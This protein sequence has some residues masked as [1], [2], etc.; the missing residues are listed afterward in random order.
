[1][2]DSLRRISR[3]AGGRGGFAAVTTMCIVMVIALMTA[4]TYM[5][6]QSQMRASLKTREFLKAK[7]IAE[8]GANARYARLKHDFSGF[9]ADPAVVFGGGSYQTTVAAVDADRALL[10]SI[11]YCGTSSARVDCSLRN[12]GKTNTVAGIPTIHPILRNAITTKSSLTLHGK[13][14]IDGDVGSATGIMVDGGSGELDGNASAP[15]I[16]GNQL[17]KV[18]SGVCEDNPEAYGFDWDSFLR[19]ENYL[20]GAVTWDGTTP[21][22]S[23]PAGTVVYYDGV[24]NVDSSPVNCCLIA[25]GGFDVQSHVV[26]NKPPNDLPTLIAINGDIAMHGGP[27]VN[28]LIVAMGGTV[29]RAS[30]GGG[31]E[32]NIKGAVITKGALTFGGGFVIESDPGLKVK[33]PDTVEVK[34][35][36]I[37]VAWQ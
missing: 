37:I 19:V 12:F 34:D 7:V 13:F 25:T 26:V 11:G 21:L 18:I 20:P 15:V 16:S 2:R 29:S 4:G 14:K 33:P 36:T 6:A 3:G 17:N 24:M 28:G 35:N 30:G 23:Y 32:C 5:G 27:Q 8:A 31:T 9:G 22:A 1:M 10:T